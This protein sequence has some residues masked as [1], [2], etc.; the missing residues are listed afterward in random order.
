M[1]ENA[2]IAAIDG[3][4]THLRGTGSLAALL[5][6]LLR[7]IPALAGNSDALL[8]S[9][10]LLPVHPRACGEQAPRNIMSTGSLGSSPRL[11]G[12]AAQETALRPVS[13]FIPALAGNSL[14]LVVIPMPPPVHPRACGEQLKKHP[15]QDGDHGSSPRLRGTVNSKI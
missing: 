4:F 2:E 15:P 7:F 5:A 11:R 9:S 10:P 12:T 14:K 1:A 13:R 8:P 6:L 3:R